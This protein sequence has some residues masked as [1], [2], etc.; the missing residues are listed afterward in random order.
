MINELIYFL[1]GI[2][3]G[4]II[5]A[6][7][8]PIALICVRRTLHKGER[9]GFISGLEAAT[10][11]TIYGLVAAFS[12]SMASNYITEAKVELR[13][14]GA[15][16]M[17]VLG[18]RTFF[19]KVPANTKNVDQS[20]SWRDFLT[21]LFLTLTNPITIIAFGLAFAILGLDVQHRNFLASIFITLGVFVGSA[22]WWAFLSRSVHYFREKIDVKILQWVNHFAGVVIIILGA[23]ILVD[24]L[25]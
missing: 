14:I 23:I 18:I 20:T 12:L 19:A 16:I 6:P 1:K 17:I 2:V 15:V 8:G 25:K 4:I 22:I 7:V 21:T 13:F 11:D 3:A 10:A 5:A 9:S 24:I